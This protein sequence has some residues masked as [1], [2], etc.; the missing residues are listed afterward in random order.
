M[1]KNGPD[2][3]A[4]PS[5]SD[6]SATDPYSNTSAPTPGDVNPAI[7]S[8]TMPVPTVSSSSTSST[9]PSGGFVPATS[10]PGITAAG[11]ADMAMGGGGVQRIN[12]LGNPNPLNNV[13]LWGD[14]VP[15]VDSP[16]SGGGWP[17]ARP[18]D[19]SSYATD[20]GPIDQ[21]FMARMT[22]TT[23]EDTAW[24]INTLTNMFR[25]GL[26]SP[27]S[28]SAQWSD[29]W[30]KV[31]SLA[32]YFS[33]STNIATTA[34]QY[35][36]T[37]GAMTGNVGQVTQ[38]ANG[39]YRWEGPKSTWTESSSAFSISDP[40][41]ARTITNNVMSQLLGREATPEEL[42]QYKQALNS[43]EQAHPSTGSRNTTI[44]FQGNRVTSATDQSGA[45][46]AGRV[47]VLDKA[48]KD[49]TEYKAYH[50]Q[51]IF[52]QAMQLLGAQ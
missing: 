19:K 20:W 26:I 42:A 32:S 39:K 5:P 29:A 18:I 43:Y 9:Q 7:T 38:G 4:L 46:E 28:G 10:A 40:N 12:P 30:Q 50:E 8:T 31:N 25:A 27:N 52:R 44:D 17:G 49:T 47:G 3:T 33:K 13:Y 34:D 35:L 15:T 23:P 45:T 14:G 41:I 21:T 51:S 24:R 16:R 48:M 37:W 6:T 36:A 11:L 22:S 2:G 1:G